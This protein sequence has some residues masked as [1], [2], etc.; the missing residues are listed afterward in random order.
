MTGLALDAG[1][2]VTL[3]TVATG[4]KAL[5]QETAKLAR[6]IT[7]ATPTPRS[8]FA[9]AVMPAGGMVVLDLGGPNP[10]TRWNV[11]RFGII[12]GDDATQTLGGVANLYVGKSTIVTLTPPLIA[13]PTEGWKWFFATLPNVIAYS[14]NV[15]TVQAGNNLFAVVTAG[16]VGQSVT[17][18]A[19]VEVIPELARGTA[20]VQTW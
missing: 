13:A 8:V 20:A 18:N 5:A 11:K 1:L 7:T 4:I 6:T 10:G 12:R 14:D 15:I 3:Q 17:A 19:E 9:N 2:D 16:T